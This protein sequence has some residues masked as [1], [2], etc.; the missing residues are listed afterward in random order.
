MRLFPWAQSKWTLNAFTHCETHHATAS[1]RHTPLRPSQV[2]RLRPVPLPVTQPGDPVPVSPTRRH[3]LVRRFAFCLVVPPF[4]S[5]DPQSVLDEAKWKRG[6]NVTCQVR[7]CRVV[8]HW[9]PVVTERIT[10]GSL[11]TLILLI[12]Y[13]LAKW[14]SLNMA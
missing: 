8:A 12:S 11:V 1:E 10:T 4:V 14:C 6:K 2:A 9:H 3:S 5:R 13:K 7:C